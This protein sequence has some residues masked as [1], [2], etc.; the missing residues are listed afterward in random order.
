MG[1]LLEQ[2]QHG[3]LLHH[4]RGE[5]RMRIQFRAHHDIRPHDL[6]H[7]AQDVAFAIIVAVGH[8]C[9]VQP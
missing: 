4:Q 1:I 6:A 8:H 9:A 7:A 2:H 5:V 3:G